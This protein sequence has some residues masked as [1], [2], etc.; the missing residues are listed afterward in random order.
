MR[1]QQS[2]SGVP[3]RAPN[4]RR[5][6]SD[7]VRRIRNRVLRF[8]DRRGKLN[9]IDGADSPTPDA[10]PLD[11]L[12]AAAILGKTALGPRLGATIRASVKAPRLPATSP[13]AGSAPTSV[14]SLCTRAFVSMSETATGSN[15]SAATPPERLS[16]T[17]S[18]PILDKLKKP[19]RD[20]SS[21]VVLTPLT[22]IERLAA[23]I[24]APRIMRR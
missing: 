14:A 16:L 7:L 8:L 1:T 5:R 9:D 15:A 12:R 2:A 24:P 10:S 21:H 19:R 4:H 23:L 6:L 20:G 18:G 3:S 11:T 22:L 17:D 13:A